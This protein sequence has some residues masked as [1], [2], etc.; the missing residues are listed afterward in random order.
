MASSG[1]CPRCGSALAAGAAYC[2]Q[3]G[4]PPTPPEAG[5][6]PSCGNPIVP[7]ARFCVACGRPVPESAPGQRPVSAPGRTYPAAPPYG[8]SRPA[9]SGRTPQIPSYLGW[10][11]LTTICCCLFT[12]IV[13][14]VYAA[15][16]N[17]KVA[18]GDLAGAQQSSNNAKTWAWVSVVLGIASWV[19]YGFIANAG[20]L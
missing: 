1:Y 14:I 9:E 20:P 12:G 5:Q 18:R 10:A 4:A 16:V 7:G 8:L 11:I 19:I 2:S 15:Q 6:C 17:G 3:C 13:S